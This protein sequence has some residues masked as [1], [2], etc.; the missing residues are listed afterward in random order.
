[1]FFIQTWGEAYRT[2]ETESIPGIYAFGSIATPEHEIP[3][4]GYHMYHLLHSNRVYQTLPH[5]TSLFGIDLPPASEQPLFYISVY[6]AIGLASAV[7]SVLSVTAQYTGA[8]RASRILFKFV[9]ALLIPAGR[10]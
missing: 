1:V 4:A 5:A 9:L 2:N 3:M 10:C 6:A 7:A 8:L